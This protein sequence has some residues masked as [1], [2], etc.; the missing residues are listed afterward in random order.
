L[1]VVLW[2][3]CTTLWVVYWKFYWVVFCNWGAIYDELTHFWQFSCINPKNTDWFCSIVLL[4]FRPQPTVLD[5]T[6]FNSFL[7]IWFK[8]MPNFIKTEAYTEQW[9]HGR[10][11]FNEHDGFKA[12]YFTIICKLIRIR[13]T[14]FYVFLSNLIRMSKIYKLDFKSI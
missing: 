2:V 4:T 12:R 1:F 5:Y 13:T 9:V 11:G 8:K 14:A 10:W 7:H 3:I 6:I